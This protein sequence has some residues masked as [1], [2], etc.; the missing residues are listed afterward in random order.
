VQHASEEMLE[1]YALE[2]LPR[3][4]IALL[5]AHLRICAEC[6]NLLKTADHRV[7]AMKAAAKIKKK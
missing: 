2:T 7:A 3:M 1:Q 5:E 6:R 4:E